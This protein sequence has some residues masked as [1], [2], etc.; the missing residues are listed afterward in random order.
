VV[1]ARKGGHPGLS[2]VLVRGMFVQSTKTSTMFELATQK[3]S[4]EEAFAFESSGF[5][6]RAAPASREKKTEVKKR[7]AQTNQASHSSLRASDIGVAVGVLVG[8]L[9]F[10]PELV[11]KR[12]VIIGLGCVVNWA[13]LGFSWSTF[14]FCMKSL[15]I[16]YL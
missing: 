11:L 3:Y 6:R 5:R 4:I 13:I 15:Q 16:L 10:G 14:K 12:G 7:A 1:R 2:T 9:G 8:Y